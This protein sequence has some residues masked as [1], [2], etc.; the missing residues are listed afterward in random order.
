MF[1]PAHLRTFLALARTLNFTHAAKQLGVSQPTVSAHVRALEQAAARVLVVRDSRQVSL[2]DNGEAIAGFARSILAAHDEATSYF[3]GTAMRGRLRFGAADDLALAELPTILRTF[4][5]R[6]PQINLELTVAQ[7]P[8]LVRRLAANQLDLVY[9][10][11]ASGTTSG[12]V[13]RHDRLV[14]IALPGTRLAPQDAVP[15]ITYA[16]PTLS[17]TTAVRVLAEAGRTWRIT[18]KT[19]EVNGVLAA[20]RA[21]I[22]VAPF[23]ASLVPG[24]L[25][26]LPPSEGLPELGG[27]DFT[28]VANPRSAAEPVDALVQAIMRRQFKAADPT[29]PS[30][31]SEPLASQ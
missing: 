25:Q 14:W 8:A 11:E 13:V 9:V 27:L 1:D 7:T 5:Q 18:C 20:L 16:A 15:L 19:A 22:G 21:G 30:D 29:T 24:D 23:P 6:H 4:R 26:V 2:T 31:G 3:S 28:L 17:R 10:K 12:K